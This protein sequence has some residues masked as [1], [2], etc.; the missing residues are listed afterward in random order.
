MYPHLKFR[1]KI[2]E[3]YVNKFMKVGTQIGD[4]KVYHVYPKRSY[5]AELMYKEKILMYKE[6]LLQT[7]K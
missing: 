7:K 6:K 5:P 4:S 3:C 1:D 2:D